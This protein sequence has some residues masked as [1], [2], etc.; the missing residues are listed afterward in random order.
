MAVRLSFFMITL[1]AGAAAK[2]AP[3]V[4]EAVKKYSPEVVKIAKEQLAR[5]PRYRLGRHI[6]MGKG[7]NWR[8][9][10]V[11]GMK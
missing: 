6:V 11:K 9:V 7:K 1:L 8:L 5:N 2:A 4:I 3:K 10:P